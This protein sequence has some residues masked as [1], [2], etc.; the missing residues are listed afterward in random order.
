MKT[1]SIRDYIPLDATVIESKYSPIHFTYNGK[2]STRNHIDSGAELTSDTNNKSET[3]LDSGKGSPECVIQ[4]ALP[5]FDGED[6]ISK[7]PEEFFFKVCYNDDIE[8]LKKFIGPGSKN[9]LSESVVLLKRKNDI[10]PLM[11]SCNY[12][13]VNVTKWI[14]KQKISDLNAKDFRGDTA[15]HYASAC[16]N[17][18]CVEILLVYGADS[19]ITNIDGIR[20]FQMAAFNGHLNVVKTMLIFG[21]KDLNHKDNTGKSALMLASYKG[22]N[23]VVSA[24]LR[25]RGTKT[26][27]FDN[28]GWSAL[29]L[30]IS[31]GQI[32]VVYALLQHDFDRKYFTPGKHL[33]KAKKIARKMGYK[34]LVEVIVEFE[35]M[36][37]FQNVNQESVAQDKP[38]F[39]NSKTFL[40]LKQKNIGQETEEME[41]KSCNSIINKSKD[42]E[43]LSGL[44]ISFNADHEAKL[45]L[46][47]SKDNN[48]TK[49]REISDSR[50]ASLANESNIQSVGDTSK[51]RKI[52]HLY[53]RGNEK[54]TE[55]QNKSKEFNS[56]KLSIDRSINR[57]NNDIESNSKFKTIG[58]TSEKMGK[59]NQSHS[60]TRSKKS[61][62]ERMNQIIDSDAL[63]SQKKSVYGISRSIIEKNLENSKK[64]SASIPT[65]DLIEN[66]SLNSYVNSGCNT[67]DSFIKKES[68]RVSKKSISERI[69]EFIQADSINI[70]KMTIAKTIQAISEINVNRIPSP[71]LSIINSFIKSQTSNKQKYTMENVCIKSEEEIKNSILTKPLFFSENPTPGVEKSPISHTPYKP[72]PKI[73]PKSSKNSPGESNLINFNTYNESKEGV[74]VDIKPIPSTIKDAVRSKSECIESRNDS[75]ASRSGEKMIFANFPDN[76]CYNLP[77][78]NKISEIKNDNEYGTEK[79]TKTS[80]FL[81][82]ANSKVDIGRAASRQSV[83]PS[84]LANRQFINNSTRLDN[85]NIINKSIYEGVSIRNKA[86]TNLVSEKSEN[87]KSTTGSNYSNC[88]PDSSPPGQDSIRSARTSKSFISNKVLNE[89]IDELNIH[90]SD[91]EQIEKNETNVENKSALRP[92]TKVPSIRISETSSSKLAQHNEFNNSEAISKTVLNCNIQEFANSHHEDNFEGKSSVESIGKLKKKLEKLELEDSISI[93]EKNASSLLESSSTKDIQQSVTFNNESGYPNV[94]RKLPSIPG[95]GSII[96]DIRFSTKPEESPT[97][98]KLPPLPRKR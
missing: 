40:V 45:N 42:I 56:L 96:S 64:N 67:I 41:V 79:G 18:K 78:N 44:G 38:E 86:S 3:E 2:F 77:S 51:N 5:N 70:S 83:I 60:T 71:P 80:M 35:A 1:S 95:G 65:R 22:H 14:C 87:F 63:K 25:K 6:I 32:S 12:G 48:T 36:Y 27:S 24:L 11:F 17:S 15:M 85:S 16:G 47:N 33:E 98:K 81:V 97:H 53:G 39:T 49:Y 91:L 75:K 68:N 57:I 54:I 9:L 66:R 76:E 19:S 73:S 93:Q 43:P 50:K 94:P 52:K 69:D 23:Q 84:E 34:E 61:I 13:S 4:E 37:A 59:L 7:N 30:A 29:T 62:L 82:S 21:E 58:F 89:L 46:N 20:P 55:I 72:L 8:I 88:V 92:E 31:A 28:N 26:K 10:T 74:E 90:S